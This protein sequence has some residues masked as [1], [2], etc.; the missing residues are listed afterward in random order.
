MNTIS[1]VLEHKKYVVLTGA[2]SPFV[3]QQLVQEMFSLHEQGLLEKDEQCP[4][5]ESI[6]DA[7]FFKDLHT[8][9]ARTLSEH[10]GKT[11]LP[12]YT[13][14]RIY[15]KGEILEKH[16]D[17]PSCEYSATITLGYDGDTVWPIFFGSTGDNFGTPVNLE[18][19]E[20]AFYKGQEIEHWRSEFKGKWQVQ[21]F[22]H[23]VDADGKHKDHAGDNLIKSKKSQTPKFNNVTW[24]NNQKVES[25]PVTVSNSQVTINPVDSDRI[26]LRDLTT[27]VIFIPSIDLDL[28]GYTCFHKHFRPE[29]SFSVE[30]CNKIIKWSESQYTIEGLVGAGLKNNKK[31]DK[32]VRN[33]DIFEIPNNKENFWIYERIA[34]AVM[35]ANSEYFDFDI[36]GITHSLQLMRYESIDKPGHYDW[37]ADAGSGETSSRKI[38]VSVQL[39]DPNVYTGGELEV[40]NYGNII[41]ARKDQGSIHMFPSYLTHRVKPIEQGVRYALVIWIHG[42][43]RFR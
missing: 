2:L 19:G 34:K 32:S 11:L 16:V 43:R 14:A 24:P 36:L 40:D 23:Y 22:F 5:S 31:L 7:P 35:V 15:R 26:V 41:T 37:H 17:R 1:E 9:F 12:T 6:Y 18:I 33:V 10:A 29:L 28:P 27:N 38:S 30:E 21:A 3:C 25:K 20:L 39:S 42:T 13:Y 4:K 8:K